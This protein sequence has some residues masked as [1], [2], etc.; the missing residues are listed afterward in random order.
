MT[1]ENL[2]LLP[3]M[4]DG[5]SFAPTFATGF[6]IAMGEAG[7]VIIMLGQRFKNGPDGTMVA[8]NE[9]VGSFTLSHIIAKDL[10]NVL[11]E[12]LT[13]FGKIHSPIPS[14]GRFKE[15]TE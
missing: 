14:I 15:M 2:S 5:D 12:S 13:E 10:C 6:K 4:E 9:V 3:D 8:R 11:G 1:E 7:V